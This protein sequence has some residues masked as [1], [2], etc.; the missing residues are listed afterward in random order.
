MRL[1][2]LGRPTPEPRIFVA[3]TFD[4]P[5]TIIERGP[6]RLLFIPD[7]IGHQFSGDQRR[8]KARVG[9]AS[10]EEGRER[11]NRRDADHW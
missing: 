2:G 10:A 7:A 6:E 5:V 11:G 1:A 9:G 8:R 4:Q 3:L